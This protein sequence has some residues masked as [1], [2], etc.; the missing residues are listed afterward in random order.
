LDK[1]WMTGRR[2]GLECEPEHAERKNE[3]GKNKKGFGDASGKGKC[4]KWRCHQQEP[5]TS[6]IAC[7]WIGFDRARCRYEDPSHSE[8]GDARAYEEGENLYQSAEFHLEHLAPELSRAT[9]RRRLE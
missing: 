6:N 3:H 4:Q 1:R 7:D 9:K 2:I 8:K 5:S